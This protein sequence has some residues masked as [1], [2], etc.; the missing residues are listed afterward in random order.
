MLPASDL[1]VS[2]EEP[3]GAHLSREA[4]YCLLQHRFY[5][6]VLILLV[7]TLDLDISSTVILLPRRS[8]P[9]IDPKSQVPLTAL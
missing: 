5:P 9:L 2:C 6:D 8:T 4:H 3:A 7:L 1:I